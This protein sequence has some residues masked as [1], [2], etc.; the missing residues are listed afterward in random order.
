LTSTVPNAKF[1]VFDTL[2]TKT[3]PASDMSNAKNIW[4]LLQYSSMIL[5]MAQYGHIFYLFFCVFFNQLS[6]SSS[7]ILLLFSL[8]LSQP[9]ILS[10]L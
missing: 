4:H 9:L 5:S 3:K 8:S 7:K 2:N 10:P 6:L 1:F